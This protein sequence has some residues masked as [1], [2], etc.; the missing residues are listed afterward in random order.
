MFVNKYLWKFSQ[1]HIAQK[2]REGI[3]K[4]VHICQMSYLSRSPTSTSVAFVMLAVSFFSWP[5]YTSGFSVLARGCTR[6][7]I[8]RM[9]LRDTLDTHVC[10]LRRLRTGER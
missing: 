3:L 7:C 8:S 10:P 9:D 6:G 2:M 4:R 1:E 5:A